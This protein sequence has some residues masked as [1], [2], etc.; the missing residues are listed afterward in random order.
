LK[1][2]VD[3]SVTACAVDLN[4]NCPTIMSV[5]GTLDKTKAI[6]CLL[7]MSLLI[8]YLLDVKYIYPWNLFFEAR[9]S[10]HKGGV[11]WVR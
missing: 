1:I 6:I 9:K 11:W 7:L 2:N 5:Y 8:L 10:S 4:I 3:F